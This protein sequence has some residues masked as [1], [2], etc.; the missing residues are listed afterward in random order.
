MSNQAGR[1]EYLCSP[2][3]GISKI[4]LRKIRRALFPVSTNNYK[5][6]L[7]PWQGDREKQR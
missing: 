7:I 3:I 4:S 5:L 6:F 1:V 2:I